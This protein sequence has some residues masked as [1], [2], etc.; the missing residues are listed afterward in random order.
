MAVRFSFYVSMWCLAACLWG[1]IPFQALAAKTPEAAVNAATFEAEQTRKERMFA[2]EVRPKLFEAGFGSLEELADESRDSYYD[3][4][5]D[6]R[7]MERGTGPLS[8]M[9]WRYAA[10]P[11]IQAKLLAGLTQSSLTREVRIA[12]FKAQHRLLC[13]CLEALRQE[14][15]NRSAYYSE[16]SESRQLVFW[17]D[18]RLLYNDDSR[19]WEE[20]P[21]AEQALR[22]KK[23]AF[24][25]STLPIFLAMYEEDAPA[26]HLASMAA[27]GM[28]A[29]TPW[30]ERQSGSEQPA[31][32]LQDV[33]EIREIAPEAML[34]LWNKRDD[35]TFRSFAGKL[36]ASGA[37]TPDMRLKAL[38]LASH[39]PGKSQAE[40]FAGL[41]LEESAQS[42]NSC[43]V[44]KRRQFAYGLTFGGCGETPF[45]EYV[46]KL[47]LGPRITTEDGTG[48]GIRV[49]VLDQPVFR[50]TSPKYLLVYTQ[51]S[52][53]E[54]L[55]P[56]L[57]SA[58]NALAGTPL[59][60]MRDGPRIV[61]LN[62]QNPTHK[63]LLDWYTQKGA[64]EGRGVLFAS[65][66]PAAGISAQTVRM[67]MTLWER[68]AGA[69]DQV[70]SLPYSGSFFKVLL[71]E[72]RGKAASHFMGALDTLW[73]YHPSIEGG[74]WYEAKAEKPLPA[75][76][77]AEQAGALTLSKDC[78]KKTDVAY[79]ADWFIWKTRTFLQD[80]PNPKLT[81]QQ[82]F[83]L[84]READ[85]I[86]MNRYK[87]DENVSYKVNDCL[88][89]IWRSYGTPV[90]QEVRSLM[91]DPLK[92]GEEDDSSAFYKRRDR[93]EELVRP[94][95]KDK[96]GG[97]EE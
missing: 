61:A 14:K 80:Y 26:E 90:E 4:D 76:T 24:A 2:A 36:L 69:V 35:K 83:D 67:H 39:Y 21:A 42:A 30:E 17:R 85:A 92:E 53:P 91:L 18:A 9:L 28:P 86:G 5:Y 75:L 44:S 27:A 50:S 34:A 93:A 95:S 20:I 47:R 94:F 25:R 3:E 89:L 78:L 15:A 41:T 38:A 12:R 23:F 29:F 87:K 16:S 46:A 96:S 63:A 82:G 43:W 31:W 8:R 22:E 45:E 48:P 32:R 66:R 33:T 97:E 58:I 54:K 51:K 68:N 74:V 52:L 88:A 64:A 70:C 37:G 81:P 57:E 62:P 13:V 79:R 72:L 56:A 59:E 10:F 11:D 7:D 60:Y 1:A 71:P 40:Y 19:I 6:D 65:S 77:P 84:V 55:R 73:F 49:T